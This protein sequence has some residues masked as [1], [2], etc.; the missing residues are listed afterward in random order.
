MPSVNSSQWQE[1]A[2]GFFSSSGVKLKEAG[3]SAGTFVG[4]VAKDAKGNAADVA[5]RVGSLFK[6]R[7]ALIQQPATRHAVQ[8]R[9]IC[10]AATTGTFLRKG[11]SETKDK[12]VVGKV[13]VEEVAKKTAQKSKTI[14]TDL[15]RWQKGVAS[16]DLFGVPIEV[17]VQK[18]QSSR[19]IPHIL[20]RCADYLVLSGLNS[21][22]LFKSDG[23]E[24]VLQRLV[25]MYNQDP[26]APLPEGTNPVDVAA[27]AKCYLASLPEPLVTFE[28]YNEIRGAHTNLNALRNILKKLPNVNYMT[29]EFTTALFLRISQKALLNKMDARSLAMEMTPIIMWQNDKCPE[30]YREFWDYHSKSS[31]AKSLNNTPPTYSAWDVLSE[32][33][34]DTDASSH[35]PLDDAVSVDF[36]AIEVI[37]CLIDHHNEVFTDANETIWR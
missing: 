34:D 31:S 33:S 37:Q 8:E 29:L 26:N 5:E 10:A 11:V 13:K 19:V 35:I 15:E 14:L 25:S 6:S 20:V 17:T 22:C 7:W 9:L 16:T 4:G 21:P 27:L 18:Q 12:V 24:R 36:S 1:K 23:D 30:F 28:L 3:Q 32:E 2:S